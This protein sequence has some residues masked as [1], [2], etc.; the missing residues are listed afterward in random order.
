MAGSPYQTS[1]SGAAD[2]NYSITYA[3]GLVSVGSAPLTI[4]ASGN[5]MTYGGTVPTITPN[6]SGF[7]N[8]D[9]ASSLT[10]SP[11]CTTAATSSSSVAGSPYTSSCSGAVDPNYTIS[12]TAGSVS[13]GKAPLTITA[14]NPTTTYGTVATVTPAYG[15][16]VNG[17]TASSLTTQPTCTTT[18]AA[19]S[20]VASSFYASSC[21]GA[22]DGNYTIT[23]AG[24]SVT[25]TPAP[26]TITAASM[27][28]PYGSTPNVMPLYS[29]LKGGDTPSSLTS[30][31]T[32]TH[33][34]HQH[35]LRRRIAL[36]GVVQR[37]L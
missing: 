9:T 11:T 12:Y 20:P 19:S 34:G 3:P 22:V 13:V 7:V 23:Y 31:P 10:V 36:P 37:C 6:Y 8:G 26:L 28:V 30:Q 32:C 5:S 15:G 14:S 17:D 4:T 18:Q 33:H 21:S 2:T 16:L 24:G 1:C 29:G 35:Q 25:V 27:S